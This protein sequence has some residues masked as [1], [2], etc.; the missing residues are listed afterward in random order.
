MPRSENVMRLYSKGKRYG[1][2]VGLWDSEV[3]GKSFEVGLRDLRSPDR[4]TLVQTGIR[5]EQDA[6]D[7]GQAITDAIDFA[8]E[9]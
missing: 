4:F 7:I 2:T 5:F 1:I 8:M 3:T 9:D 6:C